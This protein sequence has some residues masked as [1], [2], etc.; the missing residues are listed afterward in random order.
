MRPVHDRGPWA[1]L[2]MPWRAP[3]W[4][5]IPTSMGHINVTR[6]TA[7]QVET[8]SAYVDDYPNTTKYVTT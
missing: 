2:L 4:K 3:A 5:E 7:A 8:V 1:T 6:T